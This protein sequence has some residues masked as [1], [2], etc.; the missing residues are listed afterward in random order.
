MDSRIR[1]YRKRCV[2][3]VCYVWVCVG[4]KAVVYEY[5]RVYGLCVSITRCLWVENIVF[6]SMEVFKQRTYVT[7]SLL[8]A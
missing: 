2:D 6:V 1:V 8:N 5:R 4:W 3:Y 7:K